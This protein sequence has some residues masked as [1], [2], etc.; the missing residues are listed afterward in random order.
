MKIFYK[1]AFTLFLTITY[2]TGFSQ[3]WVT[4]TSSSGARTFNTTTVLNDGRII[5]I[6]GNQSG[7]ITSIVEIYNPTDDSWTTVAD[8]PLP[9]AGHQTVCSSD[10]TVLIFGGGQTTAKGQV[11]VDNVWEYNII[12]DI[13][14]QKE[15]MPID[16]VEHTATVLPNNNVLIVGGYKEP[17]G[18]DNPWSFVYNPA[19]DTFS[20]PVNLLSTKDG[21][22]AILLNN[23]N[24]MVV[25]GYNYTS[26]AITNVEIYNP[27]EDSWSVNGEI[28]EGRSGG[29]AAIKNQEGDVFI[30]GGFNF[31]TFDEFSTIDKYDAQTETWSTLPNMPEAMS[32]V[33]A[34]L[35][36]NGEIIIAGGQG[37][38][39]K[40]SYLDN[41]NRQN[42]TNINS[43]GPIYLTSVFSVNTETGNQTTLTPLANGRAHANTF[44]L[45]DNRVV[46]MYGRGDTYYD[47]GEIYGT[48]TS[49]LTYNVTFHIYEDDGTTPI[50]EAS[51]EFNSETFVTNASGEIV[52]NDIEAA[53]GLPFIISKEGFSNYYGSA[54]I[55]SN[56]I[57]I[58]ANLQ[59]ANNINT[60][61]SNSFAIYPNPS[62]GI[63]TISNSDNKITN[64]E[65]IDATG[66]IVNTQTQT[67]N[68]QYS[69]DLSNQ[70][71]GIY[72]IKIITTN[73][74]ITKKIIIN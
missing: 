63:F 50:N 19:A 57:N 56:D 23:G 45:P 33:N 14:T 26:G 43:K 44:S 64:I 8:F 30:I 72:F 18:T 53:N 22:S 36:E 39:G 58:Y 47:N 48:A 7:E 38:D 66:K 20:S 65:V 28:S 1:I 11:S 2:L 40:K 32:G 15:D 12:T 42:S 37:D 69:I 5:I 74:I 62:N 4:T 61:N 49:P 27:I 41:K 3:E 16:A 68:N 17:S 34:A 46:L 13:W 59:G 25:G 51:V 31:F 71:K 21:H 35:L 10:S 55:N 54:S 67:T 52:F 6:G 24:V 73:N 60:I 70:S 29:Y 9:V